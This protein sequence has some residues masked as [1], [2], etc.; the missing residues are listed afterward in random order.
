M[1][2]FGNENK[3]KV[4]KLKKIADKVVA[5]EDKYKAFSDEQIR[6]CTEEFKKRYLSKIKISIENDII[7]VDI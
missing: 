4:K 5:L 6:G 1:G 7:Q 3:S 2:L